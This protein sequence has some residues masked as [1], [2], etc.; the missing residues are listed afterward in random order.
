MQYAEIF[1]KLTYET[2]VL[3]FFKKNGDIRVMLGTRNLSTIDLIH[4]FQGYVLGGHDTRCN[5]NNGNLAVYD[6]VIGD[7]RSFSIDRLVHAEFLGTITTKEGYNKALETYLKIKEDYD[8]SGNT[9][10]TIDNFDSINK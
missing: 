2:A 6:M 4:G 10:L 9:T 1:S 5:I 7:A 8:K 3:V